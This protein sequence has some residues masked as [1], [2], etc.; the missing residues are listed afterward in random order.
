MGFRV[1]KGSKIKTA[2]GERSL[3]DVAEAA[4]GKFTRAAL[5]QWEAGLV[6]P[7]DEKVPA[8][9]DALGCTFEQISEPFGES[10]VAA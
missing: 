3:Q 9:L 6:T 10:A 1:I 4:G 2:R 8:L 5:W 7:S